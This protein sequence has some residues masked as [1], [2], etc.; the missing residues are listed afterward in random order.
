MAS[1]P[2]DESVHPSG[3]TTLENQL[4]AV[5]P[6]RSSNWN[7][8]DKSGVKLSKVICA[9]PAS[10]SEPTKIIACGF[11]VNSYQKLNFLSAY[12]TQGACG[13][14][15]TVVSDLGPKYIKR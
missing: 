4:L 9:V 13:R 1:M 7:V 14:G 10:A 6:V 2:P 3:A 15:L 5:P 8:S 11:P 12:A